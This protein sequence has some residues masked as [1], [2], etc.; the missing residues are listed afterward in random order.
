MMSNFR[1]SVFFVFCVLTVTASSVFGQKQFTGVEYRGETPKQLKEK[2]KAFELYRFDASAVSR[3]VHRDNYEYEIQIQVGAHHW[4]LALFPHD[5]RDPQAKLTVMTENGIEIRDKGPNA[6]FIG[7]I[8]G[9]TQKVVFHITD[10]F[11]MGMIQEKDGIY[12]IES[13]RHV[14]KDLPAD[15]YIIYREQDVNPVPGVICGAD[16]LKSAKDKYLSR[17]HKGIEE[18]GSCYEMIIGYAA[19]WDYNQA[20]GGVN[21]AA[22]YMSSILSL[23]AT[24]WDDEFNDEIQVTDGPSFVSDCSSCD[25]W[26][27]TTSASGLLAEFA[28]WANSGGLNGPYAAATLWVTR[29]IS[30]SVVGIAYL[31]GL[32]GS[33]GYNVC[34]DFTSNTNLL[35]QLQC[36]EIGHNYGCTHT[37]NGIMAPSVNGSSFWAPASVAT[38][39]NN[40]PWSCMD[41]CLNGSG[42]TADFLSDVDEGCLEFT[43][44]FSDFSLNATSWFWEFEGGDPATST[45][46][47]PIVKYKVKGKYSVT[48]TASNPYGDDS[49]VIFNYINVRDIPLVSF[50]AETQIGSNEVHF[51]DQTDDP[52]TWEWDFDDGTYSDEQNPVHIFENDGT[53]E[54]TLTVTNACGQDFYSTFVDIITPVSAEFS[55]DTTRACGALCANFATHK[56]NNIDVWNWSFP[57]GMPSSSTEP[58]P[59]VC[60]DKPGIYEVF[61]KVSNQKY[62]DTMTLKKYIRV[63][64]NSVVKFTDTLDVQDSLRVYFYDHSIYHDSITW[65]FGNLKYVFDT[66]TIWRLDNTDSVVFALDSNAQVTVDARYR[67]DSLDVHYF[68]DSIYEVIAITHGAC[69]NDTT[70]QHIIVG[71]VPVAAMTLSDVCAGED[72]QLIDASTKNATHWNWTVSKGPQSVFYSTQ[73]ASWT[74]DESGEYLIRLIASNGVGADTIE[75]TITVYEEAS[76]AYSFKVHGLEVSFTSEA[77]NAG[78]H[79]WYFGDG[80]LSMDENPV[81]AYTDKGIYEVMYIVSNTCGMDTIVN[82]VDLTQLKA[83]ISM[84]VTK[85]CAPLSVSFTSNSVDATSVEWILDGSNT[86]VSMEE[87]PTVVY[88]NAGV[89]EVVLVAHQGSKTDTA[90]GVYITVDEIPVPDFSFATMDLEVRFTNTSKGSNLTYEWDFGDGE[91]STDENPVHTFSTGGK[92][93]VSLKATN[94][95]DA[96][97]TIK[98]VKIHGVRVQDVTQ[99]KKILRITPNPAKREFEIS[100]E[101]ASGENGTLEIYNVQNSKLWSQVVLNQTIQHKLTVNCS[102]WSAGLYFVI[103]KTKGQVSMEKLIVR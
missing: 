40:T 34:E 89:F 26:S 52:E 14:S 59:R 84:D 55:A 78:S 80:A 16:E 103:Y 27:H 69:S 32:C 63:D 51:F 70:I 33:A 5:I 77:V 12:Y 67:L 90:R 3:Y 1:F 46:Q 76:A 30:G 4:D 66:V 56:N 75:Q 6:H 43:V 100:L 95:C 88:E 19:D 20:H 41:E 31:N 82:T 25:P 73:N 79:L 44:E 22:S 68:K 61:L 48:L 7:Q 92:Y 54:V 23:V 72:L 97:T 21:G 74:P 85:G 9:T 60:Y 98:E 49:K 99:E 45:E 86:P 39:N 17:K 11:L 42:P 87:N 28:S 35:R 53:Y 38:I 15:S 8:K 2:F 57:G 47:N 18:R 58:K 96:Y 91:K 29:D 101:D 62:K 65:D 93:N 13:G 94:L 83:G 24:N 71:K 50:V 37:S 81:H 102:S 10:E 64:S 36:H